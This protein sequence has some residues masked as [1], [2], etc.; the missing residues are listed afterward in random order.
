MNQFADDMDIFSLCNEKS[1]KE[2][3]GELQSFKRQ[4]GFTVSYEKTTV[5]RIGSLRHSNAQ[6]YNL[7]ELAW[8]NED[9]NVLGVTIAHEDIVGK[10]LSEH[11]YQG[12]ENLGCMEQ[13]RVKFTWESTNDKYTGSITICI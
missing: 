9:I 8:S 11:S 13:Q 6:M 2:V 1:I 3:Y 12:Q 10:K 7:D 4:S 5:Y